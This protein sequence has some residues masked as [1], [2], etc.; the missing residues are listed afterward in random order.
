MKKTGPGLWIDDNGV[1]SAYVGLDYPADTED[2]Q[3]AAVNYRR[4]T[5]SKYTPYSTAKYG[6]WAQAANRLLANAEQSNFARGYQPC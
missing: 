1:L 2:R 5:G 4:V 3:Y 6:E